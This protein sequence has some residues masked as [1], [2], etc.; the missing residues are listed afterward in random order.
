MTRLIWR[1]ARS[2]HWGSPNLYNCLIWRL[3]SSGGIAHAAAASRYVR[4][5]QASWERQCLGEQS[6]SRGLTAAIEAGPSAVAWQP[7]GKTHCFCANVVVIC[8][9]NLDI[10][11]GPAA[12][13]PLG[14]LSI[15]DGLFID[16]RLQSCGLHCGRFLMALWVMRFPFT[17][18]AAC[19]GPRAAS[20]LWL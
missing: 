8:T 2:G 14:I 19:L 15:D 18:G 4:S 16:S 9:G 12:Q 17:A 20:F 1:V 7:V 13:H 6:S 10:L 11:R 5:S 3:A